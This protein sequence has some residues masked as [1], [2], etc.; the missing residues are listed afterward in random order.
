MVLKKRSGRRTQARKHE[1]EDIEID[2]SIVHFQISLF[3]EWN[4]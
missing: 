2:D 3:F 1:K 4:V